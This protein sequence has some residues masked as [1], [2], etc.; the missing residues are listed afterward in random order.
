MSDWARAMP[1]VGAWLAGLLAPDHLAQVHARGSLG[2]LFADAMTLTAEPDIQEAARRANQRIA[3]V[4]TDLLAQG[5]REGSIRADLDPAVGA[6]WL[7]SL[8]A[9]QGFRYSVAPDPAQLEAALGTLTRDLLFP[10][11]DAP[12]PTG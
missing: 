8:L 4:L 7:M 11:K 9:S 2:V 12:A 3:T 1:T 5:R 6:W 10:P